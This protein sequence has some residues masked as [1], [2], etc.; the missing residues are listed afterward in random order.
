MLLYILQ[1]MN[2]VIQSAQCGKC[3]HS[4]PLSHRTNVVQQCLTPGLYWAC[5][6]ARNRL[7]VPADECSASTVPVQHQ[8]GMVIMRKQMSLGHSD[9]VPHPLHSLWLSGTDCWSGIQHPGMPCLFLDYSSSV[10]NFQNQP[11]RVSNQLWVLLMLQDLFLNP[12][13]LYLL[14]SPYNLPML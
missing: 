12:V 10:W 13:F 3:V 9:Q 7:Q 8:N 1:T 14:L 4:P 11:G 6:R 5:G 2:V